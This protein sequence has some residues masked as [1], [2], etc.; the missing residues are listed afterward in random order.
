[1]GLCGE[2]MGNE[3]RGREWCTRERE[4]KEERGK[5]AVGDK[6]KAYE[7]GKEILVTC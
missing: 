5:G 6:R 3:G 1:M 2:R 7:S 4:G